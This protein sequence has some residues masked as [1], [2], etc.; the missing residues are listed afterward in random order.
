M[1]SMCPHPDIHEYYTVRHNTSGKKL[2]KQGNQ[3]W[4]TREVVDNYQL[5]QDRWARG[6]R[7][8]THVDVVG[9]G[10]E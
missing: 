2:T 5:W 6:P 10:K 8:Y 7:D 1:A 9:R 3:K 4:E